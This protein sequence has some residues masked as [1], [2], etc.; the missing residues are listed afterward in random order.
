MIDRWTHRWID[1][2]MGAQI[3]RQKTITANQVRCV[4]YTI[5]KINKCIDRQIAHGNGD[6]LI[7]EYEKQIDR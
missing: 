5:L 3:D 2:Q 6:R 7:I 1:G 4:I